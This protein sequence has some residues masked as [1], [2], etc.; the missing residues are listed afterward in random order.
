MGRRK[1]ITLRLTVYEDELKARGIDRTRPPYNAMSLSN[2]GRELAGLP[3]LKRGGIRPGGAEP[4]NRH[5]SGT[6]I[7]RAARLRARAEGAILRALQEMGGAAYASD[8][9]A[10]VK[11]PGAQWARMR[12][13]LMRLEDR[14]ALR[15]ETGEEAT[16]HGPRRR[17]ILTEKG[18]AELPA[19]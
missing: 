12:E 8:I 3:L 9:L 2:L 6:M 17:Y 13:H 18:R 7:A 19:S 14:G 1:V 10:H 15:V 16:S 4:G 11:G 5:G